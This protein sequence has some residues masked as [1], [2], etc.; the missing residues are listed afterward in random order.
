M[1]QH[2]PKTKLQNHTKTSIKMVLPLMLLSVATGLVLVFSS[3]AASAYPSSYMSN[4]YTQAFSRGIDPSGSSHWQTYFQS[5]GCNGSTLASAAKT[6]YSSTEFAGKSYTADA[7][8]NR[9]YGGALQRTADPSGL[10]YWKGKLNSGTSRA[11]VAAGIINGGAGEINKIATSACAA[12]AAPAPTPTPAKPTPTPTK[13]APAKPTTT[14]PAASTPAATPAPATDNS[15]KEKPGKAGEF[16]AEV[17]EDSSAVSLSWDSASDNVGVASYK[18]ERSTDGETWTVLD[19]TITDTTYDDRTVVFSTTYK[20]RLTAVD[21]AGNAGE[22]ATTEAKTGEFNANASADDATAIASEDNVVIAS[23]PA[24]AVPDESSCAVDLDSDDIDEL[25]STIGT[26]AMRLAGPY[27]V[28]CKDSNGE[29]VASFSKPVVVT[30]APPKAA[31]KGNTNFK[32]YIYDMQAEQWSLAKSEYDKKAKTY[33]VSI[34]GPAQVAFVGQKAANYWPLF[35]SII[36]PT[37][38]VG[39]GA[40]WYYQRKLKKQQ[41]ADY[42]KKKY[43]NL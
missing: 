35:F 19:E 39:G 20:Y 9:I 8:V 23:M 15:D 31:T 36:V 43:Y 28:S 22:S 7:V 25:K 24:G 4:L 38:L 14:K 13:P 6:I 21:S 2:K 10:A 30:M 12:P 16:K 3:F 17:D 41:Y 5:N 1:P 33:K 37:L 29:V 34:D 27:L 32:V 11:T 42:I 18:L 40:F 26:K